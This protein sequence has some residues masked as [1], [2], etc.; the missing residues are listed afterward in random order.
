MGRARLHQ[1]SSA[2]AHLRRFLFRGKPIA[3]IFRG[4]GTKRVLQFADGSRTTTDRATVHTLA[5]LKGFLDY[6]A[7]YLRGSARTRRQML[8]KSEARQ[9]RLFRLFLSR[10]AADIAAMP[11]ELRPAAQ[12]ALRRLHATRIGSPLVGKAPVSALRTDQSGLFRIA[13]DAG[14]LFHKTGHRSTRRL[15]PVR[16]TRT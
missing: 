16:I 4:P 2:D 6:R 3:G 7:R 10:R 11:A 13:R 14:I 15:L 5:R 9:Q 12:R 8:T 1:R